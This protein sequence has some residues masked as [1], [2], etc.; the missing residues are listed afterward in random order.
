MWIR[1]RHVQ[2][3]DH[4]DPSLSLTLACQ[5]AEI[6]YDASK[7]SKYFNNEEQKDKTLTHKIERI[8]AK[9]KQLEKLDLAH[10]LRKADELVA[11]V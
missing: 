2:T 3:S 7:G 4:N 1:Q 5:V 8:L 10:D 9:K 11:S 6:I